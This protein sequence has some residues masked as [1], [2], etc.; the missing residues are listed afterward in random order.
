M[1]APVQAKN[2]GEWRKWMLN[3]DGY[4]VRHRNINKKRETQ[5]QHRLIMAEHLSR[6]LLTHENV[7]HLNGVRDDNRLENLELWS[8]SQP[9]GQRVADKISWAKSFLEQYG[10]EFV[11][12]QGATAK[13]V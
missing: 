4:I 9:K 12:N 8:V 2:L 7:H 6:E 11:K 10:Y 3:A 13:M 5:L 1:D